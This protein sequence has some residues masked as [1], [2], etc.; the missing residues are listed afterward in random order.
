MKTLIIVLLVFFVP[1]S[2]IKSQDT[3]E[4]N[5][6]LMRTTYKI[7]GDKDEIG[8]VFLLAKKTRPDSDYAYIVLVT[9]KHVLDTI[10][11]DSATIFLREKKN[12]AYSTLPHRI[13]I[14]SK[15]K[16]LYTSHP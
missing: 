10:S 11:G 13:A 3:T 6:L 9:A 12:E 7:N 1:L 5:T 8:T 4:L 16:K 14:K 15:G 2:N